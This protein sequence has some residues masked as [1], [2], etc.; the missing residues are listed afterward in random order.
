M[1][2]KEAMTAPDNKSSKAN[3]AIEMKNL[4]IG[5][6]IR[7]LRLME[8]SLIWLSSPNWDGL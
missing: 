7:S 8:Q 6:G 2:H 3:Y 5:V 1:Q 4:E